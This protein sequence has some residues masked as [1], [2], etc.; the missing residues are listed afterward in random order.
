MKQIGLE[1]SAASVTGVPFR[2]N[3]A[4][5]PSRISRR[6]RWLS[7]MGGSLT[8]AILP[9]QTSVRA[10]PLEATR[11]LSISILLPICCSPSLPVVWFWDTGI[12][13]LFEEAGY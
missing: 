1:E 13:P 12:S 4:A 6:D 9:L 8:R 11:F 3:A 7:F 5:V 2:K 10:F